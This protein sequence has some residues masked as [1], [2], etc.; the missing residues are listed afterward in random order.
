MTLESCGQLDSAARIRPAVDVAALPLPPHNPLSCRERL[1]ALRVFHTGQET[2]RDTGGPVTSVGV[3][4]K[5]LVPPMVLATSPAA[6]RDVLG[7]TDA[8]VD[9]MSLHEEMRHLLGDN[10]FDL[11][12]ERW[13]PRRRALQPVFT[14]HHVRAFG[15]DMF[16]A[17]DTVAA[18]WAEGGDIDLDAECRRLTLR[19][20]GRSVLGLDL[21][22]YADAVAEPIRVALTYIADR[23]MRPVRAPRWLPTPA[24]RRARAAAAD[25]HQLAA[26][27]LQACRADPTVRAPLVHAL[28]AA[29][30]PATGQ[31][32]SDDEI[33][34]ELIV[35][36]VAGHDTTATT[37]AYALWSLGRYRELQQRVVAEV[38]DLGDRDLTPDDVP[39]LSYTVA[40]VHEAL[41]LCPPGAAIGREAMQD[42]AVDGYRIA[43]GTT[44]IAGVYA[45]HRDPRLWENPLRFDPD[46]FSAPNSATRNR[47]QYLPF[48]AGPRSCIGDHFAML[49]VTLALATILRRTDIRS[50]RTVFP[51]AVPFTTV[52]AEAIPARVLRRRQLCNALAKRC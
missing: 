28:I 40:V 37:L 39:R 27:I 34:A 43:R 4:P 16:R 26:D 20:L 15:G 32:L 9:K 13:L 7:R 2:L 8:F 49:E 29:T 50:L 30:D 24:R 22:E 52:A 47:W 31:G 18:S 14:K 48:G 25:L 46:R 35:F 38:T 5:R 42:I 21:D 33:C 23:A 11:P 51:L 45:V 1:R 41:R 6:I 19:A 44:L 10:M 3:G 36:L 17:A 12:H